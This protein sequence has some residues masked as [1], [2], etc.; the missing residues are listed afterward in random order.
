MVPGS[1]A[2]SLVVLAAMAT[3]APSRAAASAIALPMP[4]LAPVMKRVLPWSVATRASPFDFGIGRE[5]DRAAAPDATGQVGRRADFADR[6][7][8]P[9][10]P[11]ALACRQTHTPS[12]GSSPLL[13]H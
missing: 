7:G 12:A 4:R 13:G 9:P 10:I 1:L 3:F 2:C 8:W 6:A 5:H 11:P